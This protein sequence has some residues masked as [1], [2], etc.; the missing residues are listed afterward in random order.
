MRGCV[1]GLLLV[2]VSSA[3]AQLAT[4]DARDT[5]R[6]GDAIADLAWPPEDFK[7]R[8]LP[9]D[10]RYDTL[11]SFP[12][13]VPSG[14]HDVDR[15]TMWWYAARNA[16]GE[17]IDAPALLL[18]HSLHPRMP[19]AQLLAASLSRRGVHCFILHL[20]GYAGRDDGSGRFPGVVALLHG[21]QGIADVRR[22]R[23]AIAALPHVTGERVA[24]QGTSLGGFVASVAAGLDGAFDPVFLLLS[25]GDAVGV[26]TGGGA[27]A[28]RLYA[29]MRAEGYDDAQ[30]AAMLSP[31][32]PMRF[33]AKLN[34]ARTFLYSARAD[35]VVP[36][37]SSA[38]LGQAIGLD[39]AHH[40]WLDGDHYTAALF[41]PVVIDR[42][43]RELT[44][45][46]R[47]HAVAPPN[48][49]P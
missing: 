12:S 3:S 15:V 1:V 6:A 2:L 34:P 8:T 40:V 11:V 32:E 18:V 5:L 41:L 39:D 28:S 26:L 4:Y 29:A 46:T 20:P 38:S 16:A 37:A 13:P 27:D 44:E 10:D 33:A 35:Q 43:A 9:G 48:A 19:V 23:D 42:M 21:R 30:L 14:N 7:V 36:P 45:T 25:G 24:I 47:V 31:L 49:E 22:A 17:P